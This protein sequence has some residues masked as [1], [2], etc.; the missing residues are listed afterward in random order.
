MQNAKNHDVS[1]ISADVLIMGTH[2]M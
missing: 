1:I 2:T